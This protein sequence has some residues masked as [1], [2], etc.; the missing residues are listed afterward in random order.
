MILQEDAMGVVDWNSI[1][2]PF[3]AIFILIILII[4]LLFVYLK[5]FAYNY[6]II[7]IIF[8]FSLIIGMESIS[9]EYI[10]FNPYFSIFF[11]LIQTIIFFISSLKV[12]EKNIRGK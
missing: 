4:L 11:L 10:P 9:Y 5:P 7:L 2:A 3:L 6:L 1:M 12:L 8:L